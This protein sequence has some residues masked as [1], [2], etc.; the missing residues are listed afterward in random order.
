[1]S[2]T[3]EHYVKVAG[4]IRELSKF[5]VISPGA[6]VS[7]FAEMFQNDNPKFNPGTFWDACQPID[8]GEEERD[9]S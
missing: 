6:I 2:F 5:A 9:G 4:V 7:A 8:E 3:S 1:M